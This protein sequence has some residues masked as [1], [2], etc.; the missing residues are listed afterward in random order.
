MGVRVFCSWGVVL[1]SAE[2]WGAQRTVTEISRWEVPAATSTEAGL[3]YALLGRASHLLGQ[4][5]RP[6]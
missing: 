2:W 1:G 3:R 4:R 5:A 6:G